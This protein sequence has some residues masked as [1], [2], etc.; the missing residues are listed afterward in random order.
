M[1][2]WFIMKDS[3][4]HRQNAL[5]WRRCNTNAARS[6]FVKEH[7]VRWSELLRLSYFD[8]IRFIVIDPMHCLFLGIARWIVKQIWVDENILTQSDLRSIQKKMNDFQVPTDLGRIP[9]NIHGGEGFSNFT[10]DQWRNFFLIYATVLLWDY[11]QPKDRK[12]L[13]YFVSV[14]K[15]LVKRIVEVD[16]MG[17]AHSALIEIIK[18]IEENYGEGKITP[19]LHLSLHLCECAHD[20]GPLYSFWYFSFERMNGILGKTN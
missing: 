4:K 12:I 18:L 2:E 17:E 11:L 6:R 8:P 13:T 14:C 16:E 1:D 10:V 20:Y 3:A 7:G 15:I 9:S 5:D 19:N